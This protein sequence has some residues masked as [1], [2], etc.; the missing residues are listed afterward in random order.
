MKIPQRNFKGWPK[1]DFILKEGRNLVILYVHMAQ[2]G[3]TS[4]LPM[5]QQQCDIGSQVV[6]IQSLA[7]YSSLRTILS[8]PCPI[9]HCSAQHCSESWST[10]CQ[11]SLT[12]WDSLNVQEIEMVSS[13]KS[14]QQQR[15]VDG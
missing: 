6:M 7:N 15:I 5:L 9:L 8:T 2:D 1:K 13:T 12:D 11:G 4:W 10:T 14:A 3:I